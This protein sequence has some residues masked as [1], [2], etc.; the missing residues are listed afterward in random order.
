MTQRRLTI[1]L[2]WSVL[3]LVLAMVKGGTAAVYVRWAFVVAGGLWIAMVLFKGMMCKPGPKLQGTLRTAYPWLHRGMYAV[4]AIAV[5][6]N[7]AALLGL[8][9]HDTGWTALLVLLGAG[10]LHGLFHFWRHNALFDGALRTM[11]PRF[12]HK[13]L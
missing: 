9:P 13:Y 10:A 2:H 12:T 5:G 1:I 11:L 4:L 6:M 8:A 3:M 7:A